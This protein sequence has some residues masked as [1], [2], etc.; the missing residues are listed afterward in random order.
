[1][2]TDDELNRLCMVLGNSPKGKDLG[3]L[4]SLK[5]EL[6]VG[7]ICTL[8]WGDI[9][10]SGGYMSV[11]RTIQRIKLADDGES[12]TTLYFGEPK[13]MNYRRK[14]P[15]SPALITILSSNAG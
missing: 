4:L 12:K 1:M 9:S 3:I 2:F 11:N 13:S 8:K 7:E 10:L 5:T 15:L 14:I 6:R